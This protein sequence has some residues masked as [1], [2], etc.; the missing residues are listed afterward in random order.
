MGFNCFITF[1]GRRSTVS[2]HLEIERKYSAEPD[3]VVPDLTDLPGCAS[4]SEP[5][6][7]ELVASYYDT[8]DLRL[9]AHGITLRRRLGG[10]DAGW[11]LKL[12]VGPG[13]RRELHAPLGAGGQR[14]PAR[15]ARLVS[16]YARGR[17]LRAVARLETARTVVRLLDDAGAVLAVVADDAVTGQVVKQG[18]R[19]AGS[20]RAAGN[21]R[22]DQPAA[23]AWR[24]IEIELDQGPQK[25]LKATGKRI[26]RAGATTAGAESKLAR[27][28]GDRVPDRPVAVPDGTPGT[29][30]EALTA[31]IAAQVR[32]MLQYDP[33]VR[34]AE[35]DSVHKMRVAVRRTRSIL[36]TY[37]S[38][39]D[40]AEAAPLDTELRWLADALG[41]VRDL[42]VLQERFEARLA[43]LAE[44]PENTQDREAP[45][46]P[47]EPQALAAVQSPATVQALA[48]PQAP[49]EPQAASAPQAP[50]EPQAPAPQPPAAVQAPRWLADLAAQVKAAHRRLLTELGGERYFALLDALEEFVADPPTTTAA[51]RKAEKALPRIVTRACERA[52]RALDEAER[53]ATPR[54]R[55]EARHRARRAAK[56]A[57]YTAESAVPVLG[58]AASEVAAAAE[59]MQE[60]L[61][62]YQDGV[63][64][65]DY[66]SRIAASVLDA[67]EPAPREAFTLGM[68]IGVERCAAERALHEIAPAW[69]E[70]SAL[71]RPFDR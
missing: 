49:S 46:A 13:V 56:R 39:L 7:Q 35:Y 44:A 9:A 40:P 17:R 31:Y 6:T 63:I 28:L 41:E 43:D 22:A 27:L 23:E 62:S 38:A 34:L 68:L 8:S 4:V 18:G 5:S 37:R 20:A 26:R 52:G 11:H 16:A 61:G 67:A 25:L 42:E 36:R 2:D 15:L 47:A 29:V 33:R 14:V 58:D 70:A 64:A 48:A 59:R 65:Q 3:F 24:E 53:L 21:G 1:G 57:R 45:Q 30:G 50:S 12:P 69:R 10:D 66:L 19:S 55:E 71:R 54:E 32:T 60:T 51:G